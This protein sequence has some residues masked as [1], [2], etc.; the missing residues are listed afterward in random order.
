MEKSI[1]EIEQEMNKLEDEKMDTKAINGPEDVYAQYFYIYG[2]M[3]DN[4]VDQLSA[5]QAKRL[6]KAL[7]KYP[8]VEEMSHNKAVEKNV[9]VIGER[10]IQAK[11]MMILHTLTEQAMKEQ[12]ESKTS[13]QTIKEN[14]ENGKENT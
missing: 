12:E 9:L 5:R 4:Y 3:Y 14:T 2:Q 13:E 11:Q 6:L 8:L 1:N 7:V 10:L